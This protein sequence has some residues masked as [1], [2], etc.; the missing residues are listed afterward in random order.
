[1]RRIVFALVLAL[2]AGCGTRPPL[3]PTDD[4][5][6]ACVTGSACNVT[7]YLGECV[8]ELMTIGRDPQELA[9]SRPLSAALV[10]CLVAAGTDCDAARGCVN[11]GTSATSCDGMPARCDG[12]ILRYC[13]GDLPPRYSAAFDCSSVGLHC[14]A[15]TNGAPGCAFGT[16]GETGVV[17]DGN[18]AYFCDNR[19][20]AHRSYCDDFGAVC[21]TDPVT[22]AAGCLATGPSCSSLHSH[23]DG[24]TL[25]ECGGGHEERIDCGAQ[26]LRCVSDGQ[27]GRCA[28]DTKCSV[29]T[30]GQTCSDGRLTYCFEGLVLTVDCIAAG[31]TGCTQSACTP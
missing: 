26:G 9:A 24:D 25:V 19:L 11:L 16:C 30:Y 2:V 17:C 23:C 5:I 3:L 13:S 22:G 20:L 12:D 21:G 15:D 4:V 1:L 8:S 27:D 29:D 10:P 6:R 7:D 18:T 28:N 31:F 14:L